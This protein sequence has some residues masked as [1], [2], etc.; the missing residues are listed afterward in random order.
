M[1]VT[2]AVEHKFVAL[3]YN[4]AEAGRMRK[5]G[6]ATLPGLQEGK[7]PMGVP[8]EAVCLMFAAPSAHG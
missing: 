1:Y 2:K 6:A 8:K 3:C 4:R 5:P 7:A